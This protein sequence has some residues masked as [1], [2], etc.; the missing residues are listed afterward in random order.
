MWATGMNVDDIPCEVYGQIAKDAAC[1]NLVS[2]RVH[3]L[4]GGL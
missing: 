4:L 3:F 1:E 2:P